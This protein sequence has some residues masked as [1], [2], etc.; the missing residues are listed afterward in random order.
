[1]T[2]HGNDAWTRV[3]RLFWSVLGVSVR[4][5]EVSDTQIRHDKATFLEGRSDLNGN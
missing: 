1:M 3:H 5:C 2:R 4:T